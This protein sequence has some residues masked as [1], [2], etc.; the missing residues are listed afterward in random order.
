MK[1]L[2]FDLDGTLLTSDKTIAPSTRSA[3]LEARQ[4]GV[5]AFIATGRSFYL[6]KMLGWTD[7]DF[8]LFDG[9]V[10]CNGGCI[11]LDGE[12]HC[13]L[14]DPQAIRIVLEEA[15]RFPEVHMSLHGPRDEH[16]FNFTM[17]KALWGPWGLCQERILPL[18]D[19]IIQGCIKLLLFYDELVNSTRVLPPELFSRIQA[20]CEGLANVYLT[21]QGRA[22]QMVS[23]NSG[24]RAGIEFVRKRLGLQA[25]D[26]AVFGDDLNDMDMLS[27]YPNSVAMGNG[28]PQVKTAARYITLSCDEDGI[29]YALK[30]LLHII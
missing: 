17:P 18:D 13:S 4:R 6:D 20:R 27:F 5:K 29:A 3:I 2:F 7:E 1:A 28:A 26:V 11:C 8:A 15:A 14:I 9:G 30:T 23:C 16:A 25:E 21:D 19:R 24:K 12:T 22:I 10:Y